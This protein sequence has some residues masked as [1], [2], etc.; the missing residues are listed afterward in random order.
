MNWCKNDIRKAILHLKQEK[1]PLNPVGFYKGNSEQASQLLRK[2]FGPSAT[3]KDL[4]LESFRKFGSWTF[5]LKDLGLFTPAPRLPYNQFWNKQLIV[6]SIQ[7][8]EAH[9]IPLSVKFIWRDRS[10]QTSQLIEKVVGRVTTG[11]SL[12]EVA[13]RYFGS[14]DKALIASGIN[15]L[16][17]RGK[18]FW[19]RD[20]IIQ[21]VK[22]LHQE[23]IALSCWQI[24][25]NRSQR[26][27]SVIAF[28]LGKPEKG[29]SLL[30][31]SYRM[32]GSWDMALYAAG[33]SP[34]QYRLRA[35]RWEK[36]RIVRIIKKLHKEKVQLNAKS[37]S[38]NKSQKCQEILLNFTG[39]N[40]SSGTFYHIAR[41]K[42]NSW[43]SALRAAGLDPMLIRLVGL[44]CPRDRKQIVSFLENISNK[45]YLL[46]YS[47][48][49]KQSMNIRYCNGIFLSNDVSGHSILSASKI[50]FGS[51][52]DTLIGA[53]F[54]PDKIRLKCRPH[55]TMLP[56]LPIQYEDT[57]GPKGERYVTG[58]LGF[59]PQTPEQVSDSKELRVGVT[60]ALAELN[61]NEQELAEIIFDSILE[62]DS[63]KNRNELIDRILASCKF[64]ITREAV[65]SFFLKLSQDKT[66]TALYSSN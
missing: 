37:L 60:R 27:R 32:F 46:N 26:F 63:Y 4:Y 7:I 15:P 64:S 12:H 8:L 5:A 44:K 40:C 14:W 13:R 18:K 31:A 62:I 3:T 21:I 16:H 10:Q 38:R 39:R 9:K 48:I 1:V 17:I 50:V 57:R 61:K 2:H 55:A 58:F 6:A 36:P 54:N 20:R 19:T 23:G 47:S 66:L 24:N 51:W 65:I 29:K 45:L 35:F 30:D 42:F 25:N 43:D 49:Q 28:V 33:L 22:L 34:A 59:S 11:S 41:K 53:S 52:D 56:V